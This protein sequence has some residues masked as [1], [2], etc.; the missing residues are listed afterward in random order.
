MRLAFNAVRISSTQWQ[1][2]LTISS[3][4]YRVQ[5]DINSTDLSEISS[6]QPSRPCSSGC[7]SWGSA[8]ESPVY[9]TLKPFYQFLMNGYF[10]AANT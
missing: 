3:L 2:I 8:W 10:E 4:T 7:R 9:K 6:R 1:P 5:K